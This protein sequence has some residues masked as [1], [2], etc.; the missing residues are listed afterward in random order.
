MGGLGGLDML[1]DDISKLDQVD[2]GEERFPRTES[3]RS[4]VMSE[5]L[6]LASDLY[7]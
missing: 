1:A 5:P 4:F 7:S 6:S 3:T 2:A